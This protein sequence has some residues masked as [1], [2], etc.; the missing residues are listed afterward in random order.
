MAFFPPSS[1][2]TNTD[3]D[4]VTSA[5]MSA[6]VVGF[7]VSA[8][9]YQ[10]V[11]SMLP[12]QAT[13][14]YIYFFLPLLTR[15]TETFVSFHKQRSQFPMSKRNDQVGGKATRDLLKKLMTNQRETM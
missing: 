10:R 12:Q 15:A 9:L 4:H 13:S 8:S 2:E 7:G 6:L 11:S 1:A 3:S 5:V 14:L